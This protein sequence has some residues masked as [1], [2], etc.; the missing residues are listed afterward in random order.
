MTAPERQAITQPGRDRPG[1]LAHDRGRA[2]EASGDTCAASDHFVFGGGAL[3]LGVAAGQALIAMSGDIDEASH[4]DLVGIL[5][6][7]AQNPGPIQIDMTA[8]E[9]CDLAGLRAILGLTGASHDA[10]GPR[11]VALHGLAPHL[12]KVL[13]IVGWDATPGLTLHAPV[14]AAANPEPARGTA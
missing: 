4:L 13:R 12:A 9:Y 14:P 2:D 8:V 7:V 5:H 1:R 10:A 6:R 11:S 3:R